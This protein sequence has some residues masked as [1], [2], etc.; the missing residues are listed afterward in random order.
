MK[1]RSGRGPAEP[2]DLGAQE[3]GPGEVLQVEYPNVPR[4]GG[5]S[6]RGGGRHEAMWLGNVRASPGEFPEAGRA[7]CLCKSQQMRPWARSG[8]CLFLKSGGIGPA[9]PTLHTLTVSVS[10]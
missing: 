10:V 7:G 8:P 6:G 2:S 1:A 9:L 4:S 5:R 3:A